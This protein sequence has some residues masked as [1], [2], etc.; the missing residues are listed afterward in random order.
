VVGGDY[1]TTTNGKASGH[2]AVNDDD[3]CV[4]TEA[5]I[6]LLIIIVEAL[7]DGLLPSDRNSCRSFSVSSGTRPHWVR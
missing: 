2:P 6:G 5:G 4:K 1:S 3:E 7:D